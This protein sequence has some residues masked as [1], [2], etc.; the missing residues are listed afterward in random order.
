MSNSN[1]LWEVFSL[2]LAT[3]LAYRGYKR[4]SLT[5]AGAGA[6]CFVGTVCLGSGKLP[7]A[8]LLLFYY[9][10][11]L[12][13]RIGKEQKAQWD[14]DIHKSS[15]G[16]LQVLCTAGLGVSCLLLRR[17]T[18]AQPSCEHRDPYLLAYIGS[19]A[20]VLGDTLASELGILSQR[21]P[22]LL[23]TLRPVPRGV[24]GGCSREGLLCS[25]LG[26]LAIGGASA[27]YFLLA[28]SGP[29]CPSPAPLPHLLALCLG[30]AAAGLLGSLA[31]SLLGAT[32]QASYYCD[33]KVLCSAPA[34]AT[35][36]PL[37]AGPFEAWPRHS[38]SGA[39]LFYHVS[40][41]PLLSNEAVNL[42]SS[43]LSAAL[44]VLAL[45]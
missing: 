26:G 44:L 2:L 45:L 32:L 28:G 8:L 40:G 21:P 9:S 37:P 19:L 27:L 7:G 16:A 3:V 43:A 25:A 1:T 15:R 24:N 14:G 23:T 6:A 39:L 36:A 18:A 29:A 38:P 10:G 41:L 13:T 35:L 30:G 22:L 33:G 20:C 11:T 12:A 4:G 42:L 5:L 34:H 17:Y 31:D